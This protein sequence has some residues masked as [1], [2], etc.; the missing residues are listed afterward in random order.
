M[1]VQ[2]E[3]SDPGRYDKGHAVAERY[4]R[5]GLAVKLNVAAR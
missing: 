3:A 1:N 2:V 5:S 4:L